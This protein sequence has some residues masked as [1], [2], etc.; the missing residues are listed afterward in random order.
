M[1]TNPQDDSAITQKGDVEPLFSGLLFVVPIPVCRASVSF[2]KN[3]LWR[4]SVRISGRRSVT[5]LTLFLIFSGTQAH[6]NKFLNTPVVKQE[7]PVWCWAAVT[8]MV[9]RAYNKP[10]VSPRGYQCGIVA[11]NSVDKN[12]AE[13]VYKCDLSSC[14]RGAS[15]FSEMMQLLA[16]WHLRQKTAQTIVAIHCV[17]TAPYF[18][19]CPKPN[20][21]DR[22]FTV[23][24]ENDA[25]TFETVKAYIDNHVPLIA[26]VTVDSFLALSSGSLK[27]QLRKLIE[28]GHVVLIDGYITEDGV[29]KL[30]VIDPFDFL[31]YGQLDLYL[32]LGARKLPKGQYVIPYDIFKE[33]LSWNRTG[34]VYYD[35]SE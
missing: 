28:P 6:A 1:Q 9:L 33:R 29:D 19:Y 35:K 8:E 21:E 16:T 32:A 17:A 12:N 25:V 5:F 14:I 27:R 10:S 2:I 18:Q 30:V 34:V 22:P 15:S 4:K 26:G 24:S 3:E 23:K 20:N 11:M 31:A 13:C 7:T